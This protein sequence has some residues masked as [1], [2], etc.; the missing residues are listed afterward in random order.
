[1]SSCLSRIQ[2]GENF[3]DQRP[4]WHGHHANHE[5]L[6]EANPYIPLSAR[7]VYRIFIE[8]QQGYFSEIFRYKAVRKGPEVTV[9]ANLRIA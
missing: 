1:M 4:C 7:C 2:P 6:L 5:V 9:E 8:R 3:K